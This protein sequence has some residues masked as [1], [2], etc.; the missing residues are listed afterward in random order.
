MRGVTGLRSVW[1]KGK[2]RKGQA[3]V[4]L[5]LLMTVLAGAATLAIDVGMMYSVRQQMQNIAEAA[6]LAGAV[7]LPSGANARATALY[8]AGRNGIKASHNGVEE[9][10]D[11]ITV[12]TALGGDPNTIEVICQRVV[13]H[14]FAKVLGFAESKVVGRAV[15]LKAQWAG[16]ALPFINLDDDYEADQEI[17]A[18]EKVDPGDYESINNYEIVNR[19]QPDKLYFN[20]DYLNGIV[21]K[22]GTV[23]T[24]KQEVG[25]VYSSHRPD[26]PVYVLSLASEVIRSGVVRLA[27][28]TTR[29]LSK[30][31]NDDVVDPSQLALLKCIFHDYDYSGKTLFLTVLDSYDIAHGEFPDDYE[32]PGGQSTRLVR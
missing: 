22:K 1:R 25:Y 15:A 16:E 11:M 32:G 7:D 2:R 24:I 8:Y 27:N 26:K 18:W 31:K 19:T 4:L 5:V 20:I 14:S 12:T 21:L 10:G 30:L 28:G 13:E 29:S 3:A 9:S 23:A 6:A 17:V